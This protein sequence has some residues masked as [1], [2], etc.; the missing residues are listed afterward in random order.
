MNNAN[1]KCDETFSQL[2]FLEREKNRCVSTAP[3]KRDINE[4]FISNFCV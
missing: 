3:N 1:A 4:Y 2:N